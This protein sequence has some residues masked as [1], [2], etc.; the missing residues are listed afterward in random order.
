[1]SP[2]WGIW[3][4]RVGTGGRALA[5]THLV[6][7]TGGLRS[8]ASPA[9]GKGSEIC[10][11]GPVSPG[12]RG[13]AG[14]SEPALERSRPPTAQPSPAHLHPS[15]GAQD[16]RPESHLL[17]HQPTSVLRAQLHGSQGQCPREDE[18][19]VWAQRTGQRVV[20]EL[21]T[22]CPKGPVQAGRRAHPA[23]ARLPLVAAALTVCQSV[24]S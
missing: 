4:L 23:G 20:H 22:R 8:G 1:M 9:G 13:A 6:I 16:R 11:S 17:T 15:P 24:P 14:D 2:R 12:N 7:P 19:H 18:T 3:G 10:G 5:P 21:G